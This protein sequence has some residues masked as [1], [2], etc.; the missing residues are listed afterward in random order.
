MKLNLKTGV[1]SDLIVENFLRISL[2]FNNYVRLIKDYVVRE[3]I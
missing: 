1:L 2:L 3:E